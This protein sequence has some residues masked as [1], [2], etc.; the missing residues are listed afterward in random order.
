MGI[1]IIHNQNNL[2]CIGIMTVQ[3][4]FYLKSPIDFCA[5]VSYRNIPLATKR[6]VE[7]EQITDAIA[8]IFIINPSSFTAF[9]RYSPVCFFGQ[10]L[11]YLIH[12]YKW[13]VRISRSPVNFKDILHCTNKCG[14][15]FWWNTPLLFQPRFKLAFFNVWRIASC[16]ILST[17][18]SST[19]VSASRRTVHL[20]RP[21]GGS[22]N[23]S[24]ITRASTSPSIFLRETFCLYHR[25]AK[26]ASNPSSTSWNSFGCLHGYIECFDTR[27]VIPF[28]KSHTSNNQVLE[29]GESLRNYLELNRYSLLK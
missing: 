2:L 12:T 24:A 15:G 13:F 20:A 11:G 25:R 1:E 18:P 28:V 16:E 10:L 19:I 23:E 3:Q 17:Y 7:H 29:L 14:T 5:V 26:T 8:L 22:L 27:V 4:L 21:S 6:F 9:R